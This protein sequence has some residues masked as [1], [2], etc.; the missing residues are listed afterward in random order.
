VV[1]DRG[2]LKEGCWPE[3]CCCNCW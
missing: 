2:V 1:V 3:L